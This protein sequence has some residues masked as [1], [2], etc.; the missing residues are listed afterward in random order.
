MLLCIYLVCFTTH[1]LSKVLSAIPLGYDAH[2]I[3]VEG[4]SN[5]GLPRFSIVGMGNRTIDESRDRVRSAIVNSGFSF[6]DSKLTVN[7]APA[8]LAKDGTFLDLPIALSVLILGHQLLP[9]DVK[10]KL[11]IGEL[12]LNG[13]LRPVPGII[14]IIETAKL[15]RIQEVFV[16]LA[17]LPQAKLITDITIHGAPDIK[18]LFLHLK[19]VKHLEHH[20]ELTVEKTN[21]PIST[22][23]YD[24][25]HGQLVAKRALT[26]AMAG[27]HNILLYGPPG[28][29]KTMLARAASNLLPSPSNPELIS[30]TKIHSLAGLTDSIVPTRPFRTPHHTSSQISIIGGGA[31][32]IPGEISLAH[33][34]ILFL[35]EIPEY[36]RAVIESLRQPLEDH[37]ISISRIGARVTYPADFMLIA[38]MNPCP[39]GF[40][41]SPTRPCSCTTTQIL[42]Y[43]KRLSGPILDRIDMFIEVGKVDPTD[44]TSEYNQST[45]QHDQASAQINA[46]LGM[47]NIRFNHS[48]RYNSN[49]STQ[50]LRVSSCLSA[51]AKKLLARATKSLDL[52]A[53]SYYRIIRVAR[54]IAD[55]ESAQTINPEHIAEAL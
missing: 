18:S 43:Q 49:L 14:N 36:G 27:H 38:T 26:I 5:R 7:L 33:K 24:H 30:I 17:N 12:S 2:L 46:A 54:T 28:S 51:E 47:Q 15:R 35:D 37:E 34:G 9:T 1:M 50:E 29:G 32:A 42:N 4:D 55:I 31:R 22:T 39:C 16:P 25:I 44:L 3:E 48:D 53:R 11:F 21:T 19:G 13:E 45:V 10:D 52:S 20:E 6:P 23:I 40:Y 8:E 41:G